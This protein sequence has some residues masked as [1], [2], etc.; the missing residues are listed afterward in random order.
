ME[1]NLSSIKDRVLQVCENK[2]FTKEFFFNEIG[3]TYGSFKG[4]QR[5]SSL[6]SDALERILSKFPDIN[7]QWLLT[8]KGEMLETKKT[9]NAYAE[10]PATTSIVAEPSATHSFVDTNTIAQLTNTIGQ[11]TN[12]LI[13]KDIEI[14]QLRQQIIELHDLLRE[15]NVQ[16]YKDVNDAYTPPLASVG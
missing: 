3:M 11:L 10:V 6:N 15:E 7:A 2:G 13:Q 16:C 9:P 5:K 4:S 8:G 14:Q 1:R 12:L